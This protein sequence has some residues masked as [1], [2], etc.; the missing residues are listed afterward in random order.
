MGI[1]KHQY[2][3]N[4]SDR[5]WEGRTIE[6]V[7][8]VTRKSLLTSSR[9]QP[10]LRLTVADR[11]GEIEAF[12]WE[13]AEEFAARFGTGDLISV[14]ARV[15]LRNGAAQLR[16]D[17]LERVSDRDQ[18]GIDPRDFLPGLDVPTCQRHWGEIT[19]ILSE[20][21]HPALA[22]LLAGFTDDPTFQTAF[23]DAPAAKGFHHAY[24]GGLVEHTAAVLRLARDLTCRSYPERLNQ[25]LL[26]AGAF[27][28]DI[29]KVHELERKPGFAYTDEG[30]MVGHIVI[31]ARMVRERA[32]SIP[33]FPE[34][35]LLHLEHLILSHHGEKQWGAAADPQTLEAIALHYLDNLD[36]KLAGAQQ[37]LDKENVPAGAWS[38]FWRGLGRPML[39][40]PTFS[41]PTGVLADDM[42]DVEAEML[43]LAAT[44]EEATDRS[45]SAERPP[46]KA[47]AGQGRL[48]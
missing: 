15:Q 45:S 42:H 48:F 47:P 20:V 38:T 44:G 2:V 40:T 13:N 28:H 14:A 19:S 29:G 43:R 18:Q 22:Q 34:E 1:R 37:W 6:D 30:A 16:I 4:F 3:K 27:L 12:V 21:R 9:E 8:A 46:D 39:R 11:T 10:Y 31:G 35:L 41:E 33:G 7:F 5:S 26:L 24:V 25:D 23:L 36:A 17:A 32:A